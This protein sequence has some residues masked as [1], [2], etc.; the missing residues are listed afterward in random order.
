MKVVAGDIRDSNMDISLTKYS[1]AYSPEY[2]ITSRIRGLHLKDPIEARI[3]LS[4]HAVDGLLQGCKSLKEGKLVSGAS[5]R[6]LLHNN[7]Y[8]AQSK[9]SI[10]RVRWSM[11]HAGDSNEHD[12]SIWDLARPV[13]EVLKD[14]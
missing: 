5:R 2:E 6:L 8:K 7:G 4:M 11:N 9:H 12:P 14:L 1:F 13:F 10:Q 3:R